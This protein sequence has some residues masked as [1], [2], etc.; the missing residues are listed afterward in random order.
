MDTTNLNASK[1]ADLVLKAYE[2]GDVRATL[3]RGKALVGK[4]NITPKY[5]MAMTLCMLQLE[6]H[7]LREG[8]E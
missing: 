8:I 5:R 7:L 6:E 1:T 3:K 4:L 2:A